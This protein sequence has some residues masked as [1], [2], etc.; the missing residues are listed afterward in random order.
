MCCSMDDYLSLGPVPAEEDCEQLGPNY[1]PTRAQKEC[2]RYIELLRKTFGPEPE[3]AHLRINRCEH[4]FGTYLEVCVF[5]DSEMPD[6]VEY[7]LRVES[8]APTRWAD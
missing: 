3:G 1:S 8:K 4:D 7:A 6:A 2:R 5:Y